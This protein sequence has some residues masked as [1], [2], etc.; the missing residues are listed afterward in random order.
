[1]CRDSSETLSPDLLSEPQWLKTKT[2]KKIAA[3]Q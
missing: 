1:V 3:L 2:R